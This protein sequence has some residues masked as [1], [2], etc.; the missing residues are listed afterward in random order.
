KPLK[1][2]LSCST[3]RKKIIRL[4]SW[5]G[6]VVCRNKKNRVGRHGSICAFV[7]DF[8]IGCFP[9]FNREIAQRYPG[10][11]GLPLNFHGSQI[12]YF[13][14]R[15]FSVENGVVKLSGAG[16]AFWEVSIGSVL[17]CGK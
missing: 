10:T 2:G 11:G 16:F 15:F 17:P 13:L 3:G 12:E 8:N 7:A 14:N 1:K 9:L 6:L 4:I 5:K